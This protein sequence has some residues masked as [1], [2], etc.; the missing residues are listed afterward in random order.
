MR[1]DRKSSFRGGFDQMQ[2]P[3]LQRIAE[4]PDLPSLPTVAMQV[5]DLTRDENVCIAE[6]AR[7]VQNDQA[8]SAK[9]LKTV[10]SSYYGLAT[11]CPTISRAITYLGLNTVKTLVLSFS[12]VDITKDA[13]PG[14]DVHDLWCRSLYASAAARRLAALTMMNDPEEAFIAALMQD[15]GM[16]AL[17]TT[18][19]RQYAEVVRKAGGLHGKLADI[20]RE[21]FGFDHAQAGAE[22]GKKW[23]LPKQIIEIIRHHHDLPPQEHDHLLRL[24]ALSS[25]IAEHALS[26][27]DPERLKQ[28]HRNAKMWFNIDPEEIGH[29]IEQVKDDTA[30][31]ARLFEVNAGSTPDVRRI[32]LEAREAADQ[33]MLQISREA[34]QLRHDNREL[35]RKAYTDGLTGLGNRTRFDRELA[36]QFDVAR[37]RCGEPRSSATGAG[38]SVIMLDLDRFKPL[39]D[40]LGHQAGDLVLMEVGRRIKHETD[41]YALACRYGG[42]EFVVLMA[43]VTLV[44]AV[45]LAESLRRAIEAEPFDISAVAPDEPCCRMTVSVGAAVFDS[46]SAHVLPSADL[47]VAAADKALYAAK[48]DGRNCVRAFSP[49]KSSS[50]GETTGEQ[51]SMSF[52]DQRQQVSGQSA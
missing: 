50:S 15:V 23:K 34:D 48:R 32:V 29:A 51:F 39:N 18:L 35:T 31:L 19:G 26:N 7:V 22:L 6:I 42:E 16:L 45:K 20:E 10:N 52:R 4:C 24:V 46:S 33:H 44:E 30:E 3:T 12:L 11:P 47:L 37:Q 25:C 40:T 27:S 36:Q 21:A 2:K 1:E 17:H 38:L 8:L 9:I 28:V 14:F 41:G 5:L 43:G 13:S 49:G